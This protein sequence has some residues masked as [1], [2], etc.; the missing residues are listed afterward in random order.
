MYI[1]MH[2]TLDFRPEVHKRLQTKLPKSMAFHLPTDSLSEISNMQVTRYLQA[3]TTHHQEQWNT[4]LPL[5]DNAYDMSMHSST[6]QSPFKWD[7]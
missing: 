4:L 6:D 7:L 3:F 1:D 5:A 2:C